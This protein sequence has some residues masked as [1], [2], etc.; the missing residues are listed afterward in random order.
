[1]LAFPYARAHPSPAGFDAIINDD[2]IHGVIALSCLFTGALTAC[3]MIGITHL[4][5]FEDTQEW[6]A[7]AGI[8]AI[9]GFSLCLCAMVVVR[10]GVATIFVCFAEDPHVLRMTKRRWY[11]VITDAWK[12]RYGSFQA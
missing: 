3:V 1:M 6:G 2:L 10:S 11:V 8:G 7:W 4:N 9:V 12:E 5:K